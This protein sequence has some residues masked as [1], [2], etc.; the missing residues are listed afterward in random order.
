MSTIEIIGFGALNM[1]YLYQVKQIVL[2]G[3]VPIDHVTATPGGSAANTIYGLAKLGVRT[4]F[5]GAVGDDAQ[6]KTCLKDLQSIG[7]DTT[8]IRVK[9]AKKTGI[10]LCVTDEL[11]R[12]A[13]Y[14]LPGANSVVNSQDINANYL[15]QAKIVHFSS[16]V[17]EKQ[18]IVQAELLEKLSGSVKISFAPGMLYAVRGMQALLPLLQKTD[19]LFI[20]KDELEKLTGENFVAGAK[21]CLK[22]GCQVVV[23]TLGKGLS[24][25][26]G[27]VMSGYICDKDHEYKVESSVA[28]A[29]QLDSTGAGDAFAA[30]FL[31]GLVKQRKLDECGQ[32]GDMMAHFAMK[33][34]G[35][36]QGLPTL[37]TLQEI[38]PSITNS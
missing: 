15:N 5:V 1:D 12:R 32:L 6:G 7:A 21:E 34:A 28:F 17:D 30:G 11:G 22:Q 38:L 36:R 25:A 18:F 16:F 24:L 29:G 35:A 10:A 14:L 3:E 33:E 13:I 19:V 26:P 4:G 2:D 37:H 20:N 31:F 27:Q 8:H 23:V 9:K